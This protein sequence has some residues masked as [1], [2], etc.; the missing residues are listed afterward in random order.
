VVKGG[1]TVNSTPSF[2]YLAVDWVTC[3][4]CFYERS[5]QYGFNVSRSIVFYEFNYFIIYYLVEVVF[6]NFSNEPAKNASCVA[7][8]IFLD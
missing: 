6:S 2:A 1:F 7:F 3:A 4:P 8:L 5:I